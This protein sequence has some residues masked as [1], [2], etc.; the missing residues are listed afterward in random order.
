M[1]NTVVKNVHLVSMEVPSITCSVKT[2]P[3]KT[4]PVKTMRYLGNKTDLLD[5]IFSSISHLVD[6]HN[7]EKSIADGF[8]GTGAVTMF[9]N[10][11]HYTVTSNDINNYAYNLCYCRNNISRN[12]VT[13]SNLGVSNV[14]EVFDMLNKCKQRGFIYE[15]YSP[16]HDC[17]HERKYFTNENAEIIDG[18]RTQIE[19]WF[20]CDKITEKER[21]HLISMLIETTMLFSNIPGTFGAFLSNW[22]SRSLKKL[23]LD[24]KI[25]NMLLC[26]V[27][28]GNQTFQHDLRNIIHSINSDVLYLDPPYNERDYSTY[29]HVLETISLY[30]NPELKDNKTGTKKDIHKSQW[31]K[32]ATAKEELEFIVSNSKS[33]VIVLSYNNEGII[34]AD[35]I[36]T[37]F[38]KYG[39]Y[40][41]EK[42]QV[43]R[44]KCNNTKNT[45]SV[46]EHLHI[47]EKN[48]LFSADES[49][50]LD[51]PCDE[52][53]T[54]DVP[55]DESSTLDNPCEDSLSCKYGNLYNMC[56]LSGMDMIP[57]NHVDLICCDLP[58]GLTE[59]KW[60]TP[61]DLDALWECYSRVL[62]PYGTIVLFGQ[63]PFTSRLVAS[64]YSMFKYSLVWQKSKPGGFAQ[65][66]YKVLC[67]HEDILIFT[68]AKTS[69]NAKHR[70]TYNPQG[71]K[72]CNIK[73]KGKTGS[74]EHRQNRKTQKDYV[75]TTTNY[76]KSI[77]QFKNQSKTKHPTQKPLDLVCYLINTFSNENDVVL[78]NCM[79]S[80]TTACACVKTNRQFIG[81]EKEKKYF[82]ICVESIN[83]TIQAQT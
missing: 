6:K 25:H 50:A 46:Y 63:Q 3:V 76:P 49:S 22:D 68:Y 20:A 18:I 70:M 74:T 16:N 4:P 71:T 42:Q 78:D 65:A 27:C 21:I 83:E 36:K 31:C 40:H 7:L 32:K 24:A 10:K 77:L 51:V 35:E 61:I 57:D 47:L 75:Q 13:F 38:A 14:Q 79:G 26:D 60:D 44:F 72:P 12:D 17:N 2:P 58:Y 34:T 59:C 53:N 48:C 28:D 73:M 39:R 1:I 64:N 9:F 66:P 52:S 30:N 33:K 55:C 62:K 29:Y 54:L 15:N 11:Q 56:C 8:G 81:F 41:I 5:F 23:Q 19:D 45:Q 67:E 69:R 43:R 80:G 82:D 37:I